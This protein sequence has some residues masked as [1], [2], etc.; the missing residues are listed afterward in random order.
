MTLAEV[1]GGRTRVR[2]TEH[3]ASGPLAVAWSL[4]LEAAMAARNRLA[5][6]RLEDLAVDRAEVRHRAAAGTPAAGGGAG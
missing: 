3:A 5:L 2:M 4:P 1:G 6:R